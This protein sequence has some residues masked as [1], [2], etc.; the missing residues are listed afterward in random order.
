MVL[1]NDDS[2]IEELK[3]TLDQISGA[4]SWPPGFKVDEWF[5]I[6]GRGHVATITHPAFSEYQKKALVGED[7]I[8]DGVKHR[9]T[10]VE[11]FAMWYREAVP[12]GIGLLA[13]PWSKEDERIWN[14]R[15]D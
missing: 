2:T 6:R 10:G 5:P 12:T 15:R 1:Y 13:K 7:V 9:V 11:T 3:E 14:A 4:M 8:L